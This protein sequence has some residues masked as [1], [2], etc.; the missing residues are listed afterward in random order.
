M[1]ANMLQCTTGDKRNVVCVFL[2]P[3]PGA[4][5]APSRP[6]QARQERQ[7][8]QGATGMDRHHGKEEKRVGGKDRPVGGREDTKRRRDDVTFPYFCPLFNPFLFLFFCGSKLVQTCVFFVLSIFPLYYCLFL[9]GT[10]DRRESYPRELLSSGVAGH[11]GEICSWCGLLI[12]LFLLVLQPGNLPYSL[13]A[14]APITYFARERG[15]REGH[16][17]GTHTPGDQ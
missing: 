4:R 6:I 2:F 13:V 5:L 9:S 10:I 7:E 8:R 12:I 15:K 1:T 14:P 11:L 17:P 16:K 3:F